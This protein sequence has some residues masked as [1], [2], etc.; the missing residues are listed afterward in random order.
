LTFNF[1][2]DGEARFYADIAMTLTQQAESGTGS[3]AYEKSTFGSPATF[4]STSSPITLQAGAWLK[5]VASGVSTIY[6]VHL[7]RTA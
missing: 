7:K 4:T 3:V 1:T 5:V 2:A 6:A